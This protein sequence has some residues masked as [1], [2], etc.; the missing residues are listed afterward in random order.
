MPEYFVSAVITLCATAPAAPG[1][2]LNRLNP[3]AC[4]VPV[5]QCEHCLL[6]LST[7]ARIAAMD[8]SWAFIYCIATVNRDAG[9]LRGLL[10]LRWCS[11]LQ[12]SSLPGYNPVVSAPCMFHRH[13][14]SEFRMSGCCRARQL[15]MDP[16]SVS[17]PIARFVL[18]FTSK[19]A[20]AAC[21]LSAFGLVVLSTE[22]IFR[23]VKTAALESN[24]AVRFPNNL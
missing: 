24:S 11:V 6:R 5:A 22:F 7:P 10:M 2:A 19:F 18:Y 21:S 14:L 12:T 17:R 23:N 1:V 8:D 3:L 16:F 20:A 13:R 15:C 4:V 9:A